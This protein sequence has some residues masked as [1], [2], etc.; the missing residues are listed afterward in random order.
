MQHTGYILHWQHTFFKKLFLVYRHALFY[1]TLL[2]SVFY[3]LKICGHPTLS[4]SIGVI[5][6]VFAHFMSLCHILLILSVSDFPPAKI[7]QL[8]KDSNAG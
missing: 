1:H 6:P 3:K 5:F 8:A 4:K 2:Y 7:L